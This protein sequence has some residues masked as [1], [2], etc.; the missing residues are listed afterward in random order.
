MPAKLT[1]S[2]VAYNNYKEIEEAIATMQKYSSPELTKKVYIVDNGATI[3][4]PLESEEFIKYVNTIDEL[5]YVNAGSNLGFGKGHNLILDRLDSEYHAIVNPDILFCEDAF[6]KVW[7]GW[8]LIRMLAWS[9][10]ISQMKKV[11]SKKYTEEN[12]P[13]L[14]CLIEC[15]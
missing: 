2:I 4:D 12:L 6:S 1:V 7:N 10:H 14:M 3:S 5:E 11:I 15:F 8:T 13:Y 9:S